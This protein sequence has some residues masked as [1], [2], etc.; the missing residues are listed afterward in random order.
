MFVFEIPENPNCEAVELRVFNDL[1]PPRP[2]AQVRLEREQGRPQ[3]YAIIGW[4]LD[5]TTTSATARKVDDSGEGVVLLITGGTAGL[6]LQPVDVNHPWDL[7]DRP[8]WGESFL[9]IGDP[10]DLRS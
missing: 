3:W 2:V 10:H 4:N 7:A 8:Q 5:G 9:L 1:E 6:R